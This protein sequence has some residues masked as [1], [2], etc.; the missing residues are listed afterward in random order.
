MADDP[1]TTVTRDAARRIL[2]ATT[3]AAHIELTPVGEDR[4][5]TMLAGEWKRTVPVLLDLDERTLKVTSLFAGIPDEGHEEVYR[6]LLRR[7]QRSGPIHFALDDA[8]DLIL[9]GSLPLV[10]VDARTVDEVL[11]LVLA[12]SDETFN[13]VLR[14]GFAGYLDVEQRWREQVGL[15]PNPAGDPST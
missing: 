10:A 13:Q 2:L 3:S 9:T 14:I 11:G 1:E 4:W 7:N 12:L 15:P 6:I 5:M 8:G